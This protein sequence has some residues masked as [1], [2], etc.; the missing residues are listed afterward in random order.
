MNELI[1]LAEWST[2]QGSNVSDIFEY[3][4]TDIK[5]WASITD[6]EFTREML[7]EYMLYKFGDI[8]MRKHTKSVLKALTRIWHN[9]N[10]YKFAGYAATTQQEYNPIENYN[11]VEAETIERTPD[12]TDSRSD[13]YTPRASETVSETRSSTEGGTTG[14]TSG[15]TSTVTGGVAPFDSSAFSNAEKSDGSTTGS[16]TVTHGKTVSETNGTTRTHTGEDTT[17]SETTHTGSETT[18]RESNVHGN[19][20]VTST[21]DM[22]KQER[23][24]VDFNFLDL[25]LSEWVNAFC[26][27][28]WM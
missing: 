11:R 13:T 8:L 7:W 3:E 16:E 27:G 15:G 9:S 5:T 14:T 17:E 25:Y 19:I 18:E 6:N 24:V 28:V 10:R 12:L 21:Q 23:E 4:F 26:I 22:L 20:G 1:T 2:S